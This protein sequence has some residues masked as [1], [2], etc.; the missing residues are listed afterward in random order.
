MGFFTPTVIVCFY[1][2][3]INFVASV[4]QGVCGFGDTV[5]LHVLWHCATSIAPKTF[6]ATAL[7]DSDVYTVTR[8]TYARG[9]IMQPVLTALLFFREWRSNKARDAAGLPRKKTSFSVQFTLSLTLPMLAGSYAGMKTVIDMN[10]DTLN[11]VLGVSSGFFALTLLSLHMI[12]RLDTRRIQEVIREG[13]VLMRTSQ[14]AMMLAAAAASSSPFDH[15]DAKVNALRRRDPQQSSKHSRSSGE[16]S[17]GGGDGLDHRPYWLRR[18]G[19]GGHDHHHDDDDD[20]DYDDVSVSTDHDDEED[21]DNDTA[22]TTATTTPV[23]AR[24]PSAADLNGS[25]RRSRRGRDDS[26]QHEPMYS[27]TS[28][29]Q[30]LPFYPWVPATRR[31]TAAWPPN[32]NTGGGVLS[33]TC[34]PPPAGAAAITFSPTSGG[35]GPTRRSAGSM[36]ALANGNGNNGDDANN[37][38]ASNAYKQRF[39]EEYVQQRRV[40]MGFTDGPGSPNGPGSSNGHGQYLGGSVFRNR[41]G[42]ITNGNVNHSFTVAGGGDVINIGLRA[43]HQQQ[44]LNLQRS[45]ANYLN[46]NHSNSSINDHASVSPSVGQGYAHTIVSEGYN[47]DTDHDGLFGGGIG[48]DAASH[49]ADSNSRRRPCITI[50]VPGTKGEGGGGGDG[51]EKNKKKKVLKRK[52]KRRIRFIK[53]DGSVLAAAIVSSFVGG[54]LAS[55]TGIGT[56]AQMAFV[57]AMNMSGSLF[58]INYAASDIL[59]AAL[60]FTLGITEGLLDK[61]SLVFYGFSVAFG[62]VG[63]AVGTSLGQQTT[64]DSFFYCVFISLILTVI[65]TVAKTPYAL[66]PAVAVA[67]AALLFVTLQ[68][69]QRPER[70]TPPPPPNTPATADEISAFEE[71]WADPARRSHSK[72]KRRR[73]RRRGR[74]GEV[75][76]M[77][78]HHGHRVTN[79]DDDNTSNIDGTAIVN[80]S[81]DAVVNNP[82]IVNNSIAHNFS[83]AT[84]GSPGVLASVIARATEEPR[85]TQLQEEEPAANVEEVVVRVRAVADAN[86]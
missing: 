76:V 72:S 2:S 22:T 83:V 75:V 21:D 12:R 32:A 47:H 34:P 77:T 84:M 62:V 13:L 9:I 59:P 20:H 81:S 1:L 70:K 42:A 43:V 67:V 78:A 17:G 39:I 46:N 44:L 82:S 25:G 11:I 65:A 50:D 54:L 61:P 58:K 60:R 3:F 68:G 36:S 35:L 49:E 37:S 48:D 52:G 55:Y 24:P 69:R 41:N 53:M 64:T 19:G 56:P 74:A 63:L 38:S 8:L 5:A 15:P 16:G 66:I 33:P 45:Q 85:A 51:Q 71:Y 57:L 14:Q 28:S 27:P 29:S 10:G 6:H 23:A 79:H 31:A 73:R 26:S 80:T 30:P 18:G 40:E 86:T 4:F 7:G